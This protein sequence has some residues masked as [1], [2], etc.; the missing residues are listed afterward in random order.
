M[1]TLLLRLLGTFQVEIDGQPL[2]GF[3][4]D[5]ARAL[6]AYLAV[7]RRQ[8]Q[9]R[10][11][12]SALLWPEQNDERARQSLRQALSHIKQALGGGEFLLVNSQEIQIHPQASLWT[13]IGEAETLINACNQHRHRSIDHCLACIQRQKDL[14]GL[15]KGDFLAGFPSRNSNTFEEWVILTRERLHQNAMNAHIILAELAERQLDLPTALYHAREQIRLEPWR[16]EAHRQAMRLYNLGGERSK[17]LSQYQ[18]CRRILKDELGVEPTDETTD[19][20]EAIRN[21]TIPHRKNIPKPPEPLTPFVG[22]INEQVEITDQLADPDCRLIT[23]LGMGGI[24]KSR[25]ALQ[26]A[27]AH[28]GLYRDGIFYVPLADAND[29]AFSIA[30][31]LGYTTPDAGLHL[32]EILHNKEILLLLDNF[33]H[34]IESS[35]SVSKLLSA[36]PGLQIIVTSRE[37]LRLR[38]EWVYTLNGLSFPEGKK[39]AGS[40]PWDSLTLFENRAIQIDSRFRLTDACRADVVSIC[41]LVEG[42]PLAIEL[43]AS[44][45]AEQSCTEIANSLRQ[46]FDALSPTLQNFPAR[47]RSLRAVFEHSWN[48]LSIE[49]RIHLTRLSVFAGGFSAAAALNVAEISSQQLASLVAKSL[50][51]HDANGRYSLHE[52]IRQ[53]ATEKLENPE[54]ISSRHAT[55]YADLISRHGNVISAAVLNL[56]QTEHANFRTAWQWSFP[57]NSHPT[58]ILLTGLSL[59]YSLR[60]PLSEGEALFDKSIQDLGKAV[61]KKEL[62]AKIS[63]ELA[64]IYNSQARY[65]DAIELVRAITGESLVQ[66]KA[67]LTWG[68]TLDAQGECESARPI[69][70]KA[71]MLARTLG[72]KRIEADSLRELGN[73]ANRLAEYDIAIP[74]YEQSLALSHDLGDKRG[75]SATLN[76]LG[77]VEWDLGKLDAAQELYLK[78]LSLY[79]ELGNLPGEAKALNNL[80]NVAADKSDLST[81]LQYSKQALQIHQEMGNPRGQSASFNNLGAT[82]YC[83]GQYDA[84]RKNYQKALV[85]HR[86][87]GNCQA[88]A[89]TLANLSLLDCTQGHLETGRDNALN[90]I[91][92]A[93]KAG[94][95]VNQ[96]IALFYLGRNLLEA[97]EYDAAEKALL[98]AL[99]LRREVPHPGRIAEIQ[100]ELALVAHQKSK[101][102]MALGLLAPVLAIIPTP[103]ALDGT[104]D[105]CRIYYLAGKILEANGDNR[106]ESVLEIGRCFVKERAAKI[107]DPSLRK[108]Y[109][110]A[111]EHSTDK[112]THA[113]GGRGTPSQ[114]FKRGNCHR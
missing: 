88:E 31:A 42:H 32:P 78:A 47:H 103:H 82:Y 18:T 55:Y 77:A 97:G 8:P 48:L 85:L 51:R 70:E 99:A 36:V 53:F 59:L 75:E 65:A 13:D 3:A 89:E 114:R 20:Y 112:R 58:E 14:L 15:Y 104:D 81:S 4:T 113:S 10:E 67:L 34:L 9:R 98:Q 21:A 100:A 41:Q 5:K 28:A 16:E 37:R 39:D 109:Q 63:I 52:S 95:K 17:A 2:N 46:T 96:A 90:A 35:G 6:L 71:L 69:L 94:D 61:S 12:L 54:A 40:H 7:E 107:T 23:I 68:Q 29:L 64:R 30:S 80:S 101:N 87:S 72:N 24:G 45:V 11:S 83:L 93:E 102:S 86:E 57:Q 33:E 91:S 56:F 111:H 62:A 26:V 25:I 43:A 84:A 106:A 92:L 66:A 38:E 108:S 50:V 1:P 60:G 74:L 105:P 44:T 49:E 79:R 19:I 110:T 27:H 73:A 76:N 22:R